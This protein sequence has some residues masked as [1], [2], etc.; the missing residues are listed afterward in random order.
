MDD[1]ARDRMRRD[2]SS[3][4]F[5]Q[6][7]DIALRQYPL[8]LA[9]GLDYTDALIVELNAIAMTWLAT[10]VRVCAPASDDVTRHAMFDAVLKEFSDRANHAR[11]AI[12]DAAAEAWRMASEAKAS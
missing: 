7:R 5:D 10:M 9:G 6:L 1:A 8:S 11:P 3:H 4:L 2:L 12:I